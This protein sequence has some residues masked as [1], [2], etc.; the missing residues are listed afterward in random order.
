MENL[1]KESAE[2]GNSPEVRDAF[3]GNH[4]QVCYTSKIIGRLT[5]EGVEFF[6][7]QD[8]AVKKSA[9]GLT[10]ADSRP[11][12]AVTKKGDRL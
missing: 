7:K 10:L 11:R 6:D 3:S 4:D 9:D 12:Q 1:K 8:D 5:E 2:S